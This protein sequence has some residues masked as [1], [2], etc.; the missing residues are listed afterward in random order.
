MIRHGYSNDLIFSWI[1]DSKI[2]DKL[3][4][5]KDKRNRSIGISKRKSSPQTRLYHI[6]LNT[7]ESQNSMQRSKIFN[8][9]NNSKSNEYLS[10][11]YKSP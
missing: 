10:K 1:E 5:M 3:R 6:L 11:S 8:T 7:S 2:K 9:F 4:Q